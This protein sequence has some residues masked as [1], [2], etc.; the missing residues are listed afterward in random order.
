[1]P[2]EKLAAFLEEE[3]GRHFIMQLMTNSSDYSVFPR[4][5]YRQLSQHRPAPNPLIIRAGSIY[6]SN[7]LRKLGFEA[8]SI[9][10]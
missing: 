3:G 4:L 7:P 10:I 9:I 8:V 1:M 2:S 5:S 6:A